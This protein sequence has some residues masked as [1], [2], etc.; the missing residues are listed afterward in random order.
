ML[1]SRT[2]LLAH[3]KCESLHLPTPNSQLETLW[4][5]QPRG[6]AGICGC[7][8]CH[9]HRTA[10]AE[11]SKPA[12]PG[13]R[14]AL[15][16]GRGR[17][18]CGP[19]GGRGSFLTHR[20]L[21]TLATVARVGPTQVL[22]ARAAEAMAVS[23]ALPLVLGERRVM[24]THNV[25]SWMV[26]SAKVVA[27]SG[28]R[29]STAAMKVKM[30]L[31]WVLDYGGGAHIQGRTS[32]RDGGRGDSEDGA[33]EAGRGGGPL[34]GASEGAPPTPAAQASR[35]QD[36]QRRHLC[37]LKPPSW[38]HFVMALSLLRGAWASGVLTLPALPASVET[39]SNASA[40]T[41]SS[42]TIHPHRPGPGRP[43]PRKPVPVGAIPTV[44][45]VITQPEAHP[46]SSESPPAPQPQGEQEETCHLLQTECAP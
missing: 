37:C 4:W 11:A 16:G 36:W 24:Q 12:S 20:L 35:L 6:A 7:K 38:W 3:S 19:R 40:L 32:R 31:S 33:P 46:A 21:P 25:L 9:M 17:L 23:W 30:R 8:T 10:P 42:S 22:C 45:S 2:A 27:L 14:P 41:S 43:A 28:S 1:C 29:V 13:A 39:L 18:Y 34:P 5:L 26:A 15:P 44:D